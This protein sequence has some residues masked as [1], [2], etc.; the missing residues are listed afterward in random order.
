MPPQQGYLP[1]VYGTIQMVGHIF[2]SGDARFERAGQDCRRPRHIDEDETDADRLFLA[3][4][5]HSGRF[6][7]MAVVG[8]TAVVISEVRRFQ[9]LAV[10][11]AVANEIIGPDTVLRV[12]I[13]STLGLWRIL[14]EEFFATF[15]NQKDQRWLSCCLFRNLFRMS[16]LVV[17]W[18]YGRWGSSHM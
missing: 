8:R 11:G 6:F 10:A 13:L 2:D 7:R 17:A 5:G 12:A 15:Q 14:A 16:G 9:C 1:P 4:L 3:H 18:P